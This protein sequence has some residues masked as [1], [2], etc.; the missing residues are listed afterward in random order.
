MVKP[1]AGPFA[2][3]R[4]NSVQGE[5]GWRWRYAGQFPST[6]TRA[7]PGPPKNASVGR[8]DPRVSHPDDHCARAATKLRGASLGMLLETGLRARAWRATSTPARTA[9]RT[10]PAT[11]PRRSWSPCRAPP[12]IAAG[13]RGHQPYWR[14]TVAAVGCPQSML[15]AGFGVRRGNPRCHYGLRTREPVRAP[16]AGG[17][18]GRCPNG[19]GL[20]LR[21]DVPPPSPGRLQQCALRRRHTREREERYHPGAHGQ[22][23]TRRPMPPHDPS[24]TIRLRPP[25]EP[26]SASPTTT[27]IKFSWH[28]PFAL[29]WVD[30]LPG[31]VVL[32]VH[33]VVGG[34]VVGRLWSVCAV[35]F[36]CRPETCLLVRRTSVE[37]CCGSGGGSACPRQLTA[38]FPG[39]TLIAGFGF[40]FSLDDLGRR[41][42]FAFSPVRGRR[43]Q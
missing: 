24:A 25:A 32:R 23:L 16:W 6:P 27:S 40:R 36:G 9:L 34:L 26:A 1:V 38:G 10:T 15:T 2:G 39:T 28:A 5:G 12:P 14:P 4:A 19:E 18:P 43:G 42:V 20:R 35:P 17:R 37:R 11:T 33:G 13:A 41:R 21:A 29:A 30:A 3:K 22:R 31:P 7:L 8:A